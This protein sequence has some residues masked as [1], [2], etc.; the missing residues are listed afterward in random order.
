MSPKVLD[1]VLKRSS[2][3]ARGSH[4]IYSWSLLPYIK[5]ANIEHI[6]QISANES[7]KNSI[8]NF[9][10]LNMHITMLLN[11]Q[12]VVKAMFACFSKHNTKQ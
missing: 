9:L 4:K 2:I 11:T 5:Q 7:L 8:K 12:S 3:R 6:H 1:M 10:S